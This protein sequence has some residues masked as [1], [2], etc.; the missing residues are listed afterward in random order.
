VDPLNLR[1][2]PSPSSLS[3]AFS[4]AARKRRHRCPLKTRCQ[5][6]AQ[7]RANRSKKTHSL[8]SDRSI[9]FEQTRLCPSP[10][11]KL[12]WCDRTPAQRGRPYSFQIDRDWWGEGRGP[13]DPIGIGNAARQDDERSS[14]ASEMT[15]VS[16]G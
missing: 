7:D 14:E 12:G 8:F 3:P 5:E 6:F 4:L 11:P 2:S 15:P 16:V 1:Q 9:V 13:T 10:S